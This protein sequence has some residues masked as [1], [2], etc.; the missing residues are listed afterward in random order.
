MSLWYWAAHIQNRAEFQ[1]QFGFNYHYMAVFPS[2]DEVQ[3]FKRINSQIKIDILRQIN[4]CQKV[5][6]S[7][8]YYDDVL[9]EMEE[10]FLIWDA[11]HN[12][13][14]HY[15]WNQHYESHYRLIFEFRR[16][17]NKWKP[18]SFENGTMIPGLPKLAYWTV[19][20]LR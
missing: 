12:V 17:L 16:L 20:P 8:K 3:Q 19:L 9:K 14:I 7:T 10:H 4:L 13:H 18:N 15:K 6:F 5:G 1:S 11:L 2:H